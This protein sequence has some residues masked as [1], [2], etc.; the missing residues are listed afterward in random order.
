[1]RD[2]VANVGSSVSPPSHDKVPANMYKGEWLCYW[3]KVHRGPNS[4]LCL[5]PSFVPTIAF[6]CKI[7]LLAV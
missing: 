1:M 4:G 7:S 3:E 6:L 2:F 5:L